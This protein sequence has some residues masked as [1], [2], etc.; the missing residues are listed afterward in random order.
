MDLWDDNHIP[1]C[2]TDNK[3]KSTLLASVG[4]F[5]WNIIGRYPSVSKSN[6]LHVDIFRFFFTKLRCIL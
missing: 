1:F 3:N 4:G 6:H 5:F 2:V